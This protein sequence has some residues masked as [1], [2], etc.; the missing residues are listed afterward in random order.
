MSPKNLKIVLGVLVVI[1]LGVALYLFLPGPD[2]MNAGTGSPATS[3]TGQTGTGSTGTQQPSNGGFPNSVVNLTATNGGSAKADG[4]WGFQN[5]TFTFGVKATGL[6]PA[7]GTAFYEVWFVDAN[8]NAIAMGK[9]SPNADGSFT[10]GLQE[11]QD[12][13]FYKQVVIALQTSG[14]TTSMGT[15]VLQGSLTSK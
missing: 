12:L 8:G 14:G 7:N 3:T 10:L 2:G 9:M 11:P 4:S 6:A 5:G 13:S 1:V 15:K